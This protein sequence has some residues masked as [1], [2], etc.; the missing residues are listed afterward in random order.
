VLDEIAQYWLSNLRNVSVQI[1][2]GM[3]VREL[4][5]VTLV[6]LEGAR[7]KIFLE[8]TVEQ[9]PLDSLRHGHQLRL[10]LVVERLGF[11]A[12]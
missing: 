7:A 5:Q 4:L 2:N 9:E 12:G 8:T 11:G 10:L 3:E 6:R 1:V